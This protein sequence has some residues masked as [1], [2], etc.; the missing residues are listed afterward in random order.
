MK[1]S[2]T[3]DF[4]TCTVTCQYWLLHHR[5]NSWL[6]CFQVTRSQLVRPQ[7][8]SRGVDSGVMICTAG[9]HELHV[10]CVD[11]DV[12]TLVV[13]IWSHWQWMTWPRMRNCERTLTSRRQ[14]QRH[15]HDCWCWYSVSLSD[16]WTTMAAWTVMHSAG[17]AAEYSH[18]CS[19][20]CTVGNQLIWT[21]ASSWKQCARV[22]CLI[23][24]VL[25]CAV[26]CLTTITHL[27]MVIYYNF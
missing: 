20:L 9:I 7:S 3:S 25:M 27:L 1:T 15:S 26:F 18:F 5:F 6:F 4:Q 14:H 24:A 13:A 21:I 23:T 11:T 19:L 16:N 8:V 2:V 12:H 22:V 17:V 10:C